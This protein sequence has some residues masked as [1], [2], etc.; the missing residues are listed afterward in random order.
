MA[1]V[2]ANTAENAR[3]AASKI[4]IEYEI[5]TPVTDVHEALKEDAPKV[6][7]NKPNLLDNCIL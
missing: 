5:Y 3:K 4:K 6:H 7:P 2:V 1:G